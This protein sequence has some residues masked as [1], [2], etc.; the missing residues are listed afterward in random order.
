MSDTNETIK[1]L[2]RRIEQLEQMPHRAVLENAVDLAALTK[3]FDALC[4]L[5]R[6]QKEWLDAEFLLIHDTRRKADI[7]ADAYYRLF[8]ER[9][10]EDFRVAEQLDRSPSQDVEVKP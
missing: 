4:D 7:L 9:Y 2:E 1:M 8:P 6:S 10:A 5:L 3:R